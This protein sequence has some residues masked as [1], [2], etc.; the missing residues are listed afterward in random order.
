M[1]AYCWKQ[2][3]TRVKLLVN[4]SY[5]HDQNGIDQIDEM[6]SLPNLG[7]KIS[8]TLY[9]HASMSPLQKEVLKAIPKEKSAEDN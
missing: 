3:L 1:L 8:P 9:I 5:H 4:V 7:M 6:L 2:C